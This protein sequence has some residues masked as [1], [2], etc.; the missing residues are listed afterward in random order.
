MSQN[1]SVYG[2]FLF[3]RTPCVELIRRLNGINTAQSWELALQGVCSLGAVI[4]TVQQ[5]LSGMGG[6]RRPIR[7]YLLVTESP[8]ALQRYLA[9]LWSISDQN[10]C[11]DVHPSAHRCMIDTVELRESR[12]CDSL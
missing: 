8:P 12:F 7:Q 3:L 11:S 1:L 9:A 4:S 5:D 6:Y 10:V 2:E